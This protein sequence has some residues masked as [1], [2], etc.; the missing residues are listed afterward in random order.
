MQKIEKKIHYIWFG[1]KEKSPTILK[2]IE[3]WKSVLRNFEI[4][5]C[6][7]ESVEKF[8]ENIFFKNAIKEK[9]WAF[10]SDYARL[11]ILYDE[12]GIY[13]DTDMYVLKSFEDFLNYD[14]VLGKE[15]DIHISAGMIAAAPKNVF[16]KKCLEKY[17]TLK[18]GEYITIPRILSEVYENEKTLLQ[19]IKVYEAKYFYPF[20]AENI[21]DFN[22]KNAPKESYAVHLWDYSWGKWY[23]KFLKKIGIHKNIVNLTDKVGVKKVL[24]KLFKVI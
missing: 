11:K 19:N 16:I 21:K 14:L 8:S 2:C 24:K 17:E 18:E 23:I 12:G 9:K 10:A 3:S 7:N 6:G 22:F 5:E 15:D 13:L 20:T 1:I 4:K